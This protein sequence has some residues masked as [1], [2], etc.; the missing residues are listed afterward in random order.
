MTTFT[1]K[2]LKQS[3]I[4]NITLMQKGEIFEWVTFSEIYA[5]LANGFDIFNDE[6]KELYH[7]KKKM[8]KLLKQ[9]R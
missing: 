6:K 5:F 4:N 1:E 7:N 9:L 2:E 3:L 8:K